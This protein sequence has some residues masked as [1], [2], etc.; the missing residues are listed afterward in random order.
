MA[1]ADY[2]YVGSGKGKVNL[3]KDQTCIEKLIPE[4]EAVER[5]IGLIKENG[6][7]EERA[8]PPASLHKRLCE[9]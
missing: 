1:D 5:L 9:N 2:G 6:D 7:W 8:S 4:E 3:Y